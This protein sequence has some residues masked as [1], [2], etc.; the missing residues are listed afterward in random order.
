MPVFFFTQR[1]YIYLNIIIQRGES[2]RSF[3]FS[4][5]RWYRQVGSEEFFYWPCCTWFIC[6]FTQPPQPRRSRWDGCPSH[7]TDGFHCFE[8]PDCVLFCLLVPS[9]AECSLLLWRGTSP[10]DQMARV[11]EYSCSRGF[12]DHLRAAPRREGNAGSTGWK[13]ILIYLYWCDIT[14]YIYQW[15]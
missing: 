7:H 14:K 13:S 10:Q 5:W 4:G 3:S 6:Q 1:V 9:S 8:Y 11:K 12:E 2:L 15:Y